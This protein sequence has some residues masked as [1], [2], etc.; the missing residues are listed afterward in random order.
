MPTQASKGKRIKTSAKGDKPAKTKSKGLIVLSKVE[1]SKAEQ[2][3]LATKR[4][5][6]EFHSSHASGS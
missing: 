2:M 4:C 5:L 3:K 6:K 1:L